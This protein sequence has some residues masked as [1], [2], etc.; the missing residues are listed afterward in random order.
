MS[1]GVPVILIYLGFMD[2][3]DMATDGVPFRG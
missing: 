2:A 3:E 1:L